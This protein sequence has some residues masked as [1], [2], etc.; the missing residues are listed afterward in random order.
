[1][2]RLGV[3]AAIAHMRSQ[4]ESGFHD[5]VW[6]SS[7]MLP[8]TF[9]GG[10]PACSGAFVR[11][12]GA[13]VE[14]AVSP[15]SRRDKRKAK[16]THRRQA[17]WV[18]LDG[19]TAKIACVLW[20]ISEGGARIAAAHGSALPDV[21]GLF[22]N[23]DGKSRRY[24]QV[25][26]RR[27]SQLGVRF[28]DESVA[29][30][31]LDPTPAWMRRRKAQSAPAATG[32][33][34]A[35]DTPTSELALVGF[36]AQLSSDARGRGF[37]LSSIACVMLVL[38][39]AATALFAFAHFDNDADWAVSVCTSAESFCMHPEWTGAAAIAMFFVFLAVNGMED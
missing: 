27:G 1:M 6:W 14:A 25:V 26:W 17:A 9:V 7:G 39:V 3:A 35:N 28:V 23:K 15:E 36:G 12:P 20:D 37:R 16:R 2:F 34:A 29:D 33:A 10:A 13:P 18:V 30:I 8:S 19:G 21:F 31:D 22:L 5:V 4:V 38:L 24:C 11:S 32:S